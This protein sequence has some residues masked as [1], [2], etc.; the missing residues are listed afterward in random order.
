MMDF[1]ALK[2]ELAKP[3]WQSLSDDEAAAQLVAP[4]VPFLIPVPSKKVARYLD[5]KGKLPRVQMY[6]H[7]SVP[8]DIEQTNPQMAGFVQAAIGLNNAITMYV[9]FDLSDPE[10]KKVAV[11][12]LTLI[13]Q[14]GLIDQADIDAIIAMSDGGLRSVAE[15]IGCDELLAMD[16]R[17]RALWVAHARGR[18]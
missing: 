8:V 15:T 12:R 1:D 5:M 10:V 14:T 17:S 4:T 18:G 7:A 13:K 11:D 16:A 6:A 9:D 2:A 3:E